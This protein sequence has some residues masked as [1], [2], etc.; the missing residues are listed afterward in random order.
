MNDPRP[1]SPVVT[2][3]SRL[4]PYPTY[5]LLREADPV[6]WD[7][8]TTSWYVSRRTDIEAL[9]LDSRLGAHEYP[10]W[11]TEL[12]EAERREIA[13][14]EDHL[15]RWP[16]F[17]DRTAQARLRRLLQPAI[18]RAA[19][20]P[21]YD[22]IRAVARRLAR[23]IPPDR[24]DLLT[25]FARPAALW[26]VTRLLGADAEEDGA[27][28]LRWSDA[29]VGYLGEIGISRAAA[30]RS[31]VEQLTEFTVTRL[32]ADPATPVASVLADALRQEH[33]EFADVVGM[34]AQLLT[35]GIEPTATA[36]CV[37]ALRAVPAP[38]PRSGANVEES[39]R[40]REAWADAQVEEALRLDPPFHIAPREAKVDFI[41]K[42]RRIVAGQR[43]ALLIASAGHDDASDAPEGGCPVT[44]PRGHL[45]FGK[46]RH[47]C[48][49]APLARLHLRAVCLAMHESAVTDRLDRAAVERIPDFG[50]AS[51]RSCPLRPSRT[52][53]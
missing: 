19:V 8:A 52:A 31:A 41:Y 5:R 20:A 2:L 32:L 40:E 13:P 30:A 38:V 10:E 50:F 11:V 26:T 27:R 45:A 46:G 9:L 4:D 15:A 29:L 35:G 53:P 16:V 49:G 22:E 48:L 24:A 39:R 14:V 23:R 25:D 28:L 47:F 51:F 17:S 43:V 7:S 42:G 21:L 12:P 34:V 37:A 44:R 3:E 18:S 1:L 36:T 33:V 6:H